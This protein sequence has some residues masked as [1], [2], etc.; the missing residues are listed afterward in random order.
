MLS[1]FV[2]IGHG[3]S[4]P[5]WIPARFTYRKA[6]QGIGGYIGNPSPRG[7]DSKASSRGGQQGTGW[8]LGVM[9]LSGAKMAIK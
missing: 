6:S 2:R 5:V 4:P 9:K 7:V 1:F 3:P 8:S